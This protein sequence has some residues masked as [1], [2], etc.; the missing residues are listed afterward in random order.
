MDLREVM[1]HGYE[2][3]RG[4]VLKGDEAVTMFLAEWGDG[5]VAIYATP[6]GNEEQ[7]QLTL[8]ILRLLFAARQVRRYVMVGEVWTVTR[9]KEQMKGGTYRPPSECDDRQE[10]LF[11]LGVERGHVLCAHADLGHNADGERTVG[12]LD[13]DGPDQIEGRMT[14]LLPD[15]SWPLPP[16]GVAEELERRLRIEPQKLTI[17]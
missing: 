17:H 3:A 12:L 11:L 13:W 1:Q 10:K 16:P 5:S 8:R 7:K 14:E 4:I 2:T 6:F 9:S 15:P